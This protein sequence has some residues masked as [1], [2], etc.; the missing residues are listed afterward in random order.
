MESWFRGFVVVVI[1]V[2]VV[3][4]AEAISKC[5]ELLTRIADTL[6]EMRDSRLN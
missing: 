5:R 3:R 6:E 1:V 2:E 4:A